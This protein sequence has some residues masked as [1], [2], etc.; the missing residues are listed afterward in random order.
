MYNNE[1]IF[2]GMKGLFLTTKRLVFGS[3]L[4]YDLFVNNFLKKIF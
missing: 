2:T 4:F 1:S 3:L